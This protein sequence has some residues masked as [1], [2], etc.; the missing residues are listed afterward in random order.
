MNFAKDKAFS[1]YCA[2]IQMNEWCFYIVSYNSSLGHSAVG[3]TSNCD[4]LIKRLRET[5]EVDEDECFLFFCNNKT[6]CCTA[7]K[8]IVSSLSHGSYKQLDEDVR[9]WW[10]STDLQS[11][12]SALINARDQFAHDLFRYAQTSFINEAFYVYKRKRHSETLL[13]DNDIKELH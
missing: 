10:V 4:K 13:D 3:V 6:P 8:A 2:A 12:A 9:F 5:K 11:I 1:Q 7:N